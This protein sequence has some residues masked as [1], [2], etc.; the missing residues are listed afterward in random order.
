MLVNYLF[1]F[2]LGFAVVGQYTTLRLSPGL[3]VENSPG[4]KPGAKVFCERVSIHGFSRLRD[5]RK[6]AHSLKVKVSQNSSSLRRSN[7]EVCFHR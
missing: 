6:F 5:L 1:F 3:A 7:V 4:I 2:F